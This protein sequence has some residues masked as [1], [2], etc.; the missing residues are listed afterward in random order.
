MPRDEQARRMMRLSVAADEDMPYRIRL[1]ALRAVL[2]Q[3]HEARSLTDNEL[4]GR[5]ARRTDVR[6]FV[7]RG[8]TV[9]RLVLRPPRT[10]A[11][12]LKD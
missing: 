8:R 2:P 10:I 9:H 4:I 5:L 11:D 1:A 3:E 12:I 6:P 7:E